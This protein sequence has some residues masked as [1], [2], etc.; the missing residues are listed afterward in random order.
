MRQTRVG[1]ILTIVRVAA[2]LVAAV[3]MVV[4][5]LSTTK[6]TGMTHSAGTNYTSVSPT[7]HQTWGDSLVAFGL[8]RYESHGL[9]LPEVTFVFHDSLAPCHLHK[10]VYHHSTRTLEMC[11]LDKATMLHELAHAWANVNLDEEDRDA[12]IDL[13]DLD[14]WSD[15]ADPWER[16]GTEHV[17]E[18]LAWALN[19]EPTH[20]EW[21]ETLGD[22]SRV[23]GHRLLSLGVG[24]E[25]LIE[26]FERITGQ[27]PMFR[28]EAEWEQN[29]PP[30]GFSPELTRIST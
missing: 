17:A 28:N 12:F 30:T 4:A 18:T 24:V 29:G 21:V 9:T 19:D 6:V 5:M 10:G 7:T 16:R 2:S 14:S 1:H 11:S 25:V 15:H 23:A 13:R 26:N 22:G 3:V 20:V 27:E 8:E